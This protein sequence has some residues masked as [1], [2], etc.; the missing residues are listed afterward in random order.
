MNL[1]EQFPHAVL[2]DGVACEVN[3][4][5]RVG[6]K[7]MQAWEDP[8]LTNFEKQ[9]LTVGLL[10]KNPPENAAEAARMAC[11]FLDCGRVSDTE[12]TGGGRVYSFTKDAEVIYSAF[13]QTYRV[14][15]RD[16]ETSM[17][18]WKFVS[19]FH[20]LSEDTLFERIVS[21]RVKH[22]N[23]KL[24][25]EERE[26]WFSMAD[27]LDLDQE[28]DDDETVEARENFMNLLRR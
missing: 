24:S 27:V 2:V 6:L 4:D 10:F 11:R 21:L 7:I 12:D 16:P 13:L 17:H 14:D 26:L 1:F 23:G 25:K 28:P 5:Y 9:A 19:M 8:R 20:D 22:K 15:L 18:W 3:T